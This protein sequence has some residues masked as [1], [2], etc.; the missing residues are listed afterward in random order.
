LIA[1]LAESRSAP[2]LWVLRDAWSGRQVPGY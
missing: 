1:S 2:L